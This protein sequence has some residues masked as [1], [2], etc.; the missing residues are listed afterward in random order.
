MPPPNDVDYNTGK[1]RDIA[2]KGLLVPE[3]DE[4]G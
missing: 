2:A 4:I 1:I 3:A